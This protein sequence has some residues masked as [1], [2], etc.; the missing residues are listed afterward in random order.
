M[1]SSAEGS[2]EELASADSE[3]A[4]VSI[5]THGDPIRSLV[6]AMTPLVDEAIVHFDEDG[7]TTSFVDPPNVA[8]AHIT[9]HADGFER[10]DV[11]HPMDFGLNLHRFGQVVSFARKVGGDGDP[12]SVEIF[13]DPPRI[14]VGVTR[15]DRGMKRFSEW[16]GLDTEML[17]DEPDDPDLMLPNRATPQ[18]R[19]F[20]DGVESITQDYAYITR[21]EETFVIATSD[22]GDLSP[23]DDDEV[24]D[25]VLYPD[26]AWDDRGDG[27][28][29]CSSLFS[30]DYL[31]S[32]ADGLVSLKTD[33][34]TVCWGD[35]FPMKL[36]FEHE[37][38]G[39][40]GTYMLAPRLKE[41]DL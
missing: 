37:E 9:A 13:D 18:P 39:F 32:L 1:A 31:E 3:D 6:A 19:A 25:T 11:Q 26:C 17:R 28:E 14:R 2:T 4:A 29:A 35:Q 24:A 27:A 12:V 23:T 15:P 20:Q 7:V 5:L 38:W 8:A 36:H 21:D 34:A 16:F 30:V 22:D 33:R 40:E 41:A 10:F